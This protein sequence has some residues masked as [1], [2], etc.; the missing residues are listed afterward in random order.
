MSVNTCGYLFQHRVGQL[1]LHLFRSFSRAAGSRGVIW[2]EASHG[3]PFLLGILHDG[4]S[5]LLD[6]RN[7]V[8]RCRVSTYETQNF[9]AHKCRS[10]TLSL[11]LEGV[12]LDLKHLICHCLAFKLILRSWVQLS[13]VE[14]GSKACLQRPRRIDFPVTTTVLLEVLHCKQNLHIRTVFA[15]F[16]GGLD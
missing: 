8:C 14:A 5:F 2:A 11:S 10:P 9:M 6:G 16:Y 13:W 1:S 12:V 3:L 4:V 7:F 15:V